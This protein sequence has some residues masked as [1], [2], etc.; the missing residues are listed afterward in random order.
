MTD[1]RPGAKVASAR[2]LQPRGHSR[3]SKNIGPM[4][5]TLHIQFAEAPS[6]GDRAHYR[7]SRFVDASAD[8]QATHRVEAIGRHR[9]ERSA[10]RVDHVVDNRTDFIVRTVHAEA[11]RRHC[12]RHPDNT[13]LI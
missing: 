13:A 5:R 12:R 1:V 10:N 2:R 4:H 3:P 11:L 7:G 8:V 9:L 6:A